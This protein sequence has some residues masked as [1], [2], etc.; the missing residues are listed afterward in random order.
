MCEELMIKVTEQANIF[1]LSDQKGCLES[2]TRYRYYTIYSKSVF[3]HSRS[4]IDCATILWLETTLSTTQLTFD[5]ILD[6]VVT[7]LQYR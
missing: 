7:Y 2:N 5:V 6:G 3:N 4:Y 1:Q